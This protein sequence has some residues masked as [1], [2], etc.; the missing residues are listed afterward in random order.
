MHEG[1]ACVMRVGVEATGDPE[2]ILAFKAEK[3]LEEDQL[4]ATGDPEGILD[5]TGV[6]SLEE[7]V[8]VAALL[9]GGGLAVRRAALGPRLAAA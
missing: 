3:S 9:F 4:A 7:D 5:F 6:L 2:G 1:E 8:A